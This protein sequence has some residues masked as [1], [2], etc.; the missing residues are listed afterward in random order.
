MI[1]VQSVYDRRKSKGEVALRVPRIWLWW[2]KPSTLATDLHQA[3]R[4]WHIKQPSWPRTL[5][6][7]AYRLLYPL[8]EGWSGVSL[9]RQVQVGRN[10][11]I[12]H[13]GKVV[14]NETSVIGDN[15]SI[16]HGVTIG[17]RR[18]GG[19]APVI[20]DDVQIGAYAQLLGPITVGDRAKI[21]SLA[22]VVRDVPS[23]AVVLSPLPTI[24]IPTT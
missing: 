20:G 11:R 19:G 15:C 3:A 14:I 4:H 23:D 5:V 21:G 10:L 24:R 7:I 2:S 6:D 9:P 16:A 12:F 17:N 8:V 1:D 18:P 22:V 13:R